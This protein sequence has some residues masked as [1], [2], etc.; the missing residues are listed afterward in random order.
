MNIVI[1]GASKG[2]GKAIAIGL[3]APGNNLFLSSRSQ[4][5]L[6]MVR[7]EILKQVPDCGV[8]LFPA[9]LSK[10]DEV[11]KF[12]A[13]GLKSAVPDVLVNNAG[14]FNPGSVHNEPEGSMEEMLAINF[15]SAYHLTRVFPG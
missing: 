11:K 14:L 8:H 7:S 13:W 1:T 12:G 2:L 5:G 6:E 15:F 3:A 9:D 10:T 4:A